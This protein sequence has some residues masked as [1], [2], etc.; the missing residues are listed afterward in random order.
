MSGGLLCVVAAELA[1]GGDDSSK[2]VA[3]GVRCV[4][5]AGP[6]R[7]PVGGGDL[8]SAGAGIHVEHCV[9]VGLVG[10]HDD[11]W[12]GAGAWVGLSWLVAL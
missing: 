5:V 11:R 12:G 2:P 6:D 1:V 9:G 3:V 4:G 10:A 8:G 7:A